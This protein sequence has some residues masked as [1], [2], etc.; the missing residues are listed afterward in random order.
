MSLISV[1]RLRVRS[2][3]FLPMFLWYSFKSNQQAKHAPGNLASTVRAQEN[4]VFWT[5][6]V[7]EDEASMRSFMRSG[8]HREVMPKI[9][10]WCDEGS[11]VHWQA[12]N[13]T[14][15]TW[16]EAETAMFARGRFT[17]LTHPS[18]AHQHHQF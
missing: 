16:K 2:I 9:Q 3:R 7:W 13:A 11:V 4:N 15:P 10:A 1:T 8:A 5:M 6:T 18:V 12:E 17:P 14:L